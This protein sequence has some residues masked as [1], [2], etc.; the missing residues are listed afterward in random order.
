M[1]KYE[2]IGLDQHLE[3]AATVWFVYSESNPPSESHNGE[4][5]VD[6]L[7]PKAIERFISTTH[8]VYYEA[9]G[10]DYGA[11]VPSIFT[12][13]PQFAHKGQLLRS[14]EERDIFLPWTHDLP[15]S[16]LGE[17]GFDILDC[18]PE[19]LLDTVEMANGT[20]SL[21]RYLYH[22]HVC[23]RFVSAF[24]DQVSD[25]IWESG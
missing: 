25:D 19:V 11:T 9:S 17:Y 13:E 15:Q 5:Y 16:F 23:E 3:T 18:L 20:P 6:T 4:T 1:T 12:D 24:M 7:N 8:A 10:K 22:E 2:R 14:N 21:T